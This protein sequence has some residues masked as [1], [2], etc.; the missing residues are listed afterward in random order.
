VTATAASAAAVALIRI[1]R[2]LV[3]TSG[4]GTAVELLGGLAVFAHKHESKSC[5]IV[6]KVAK[7]GKNLDAKARRRKEG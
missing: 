7:K 4:N 1:M 3:C 6:L 2:F 5:V